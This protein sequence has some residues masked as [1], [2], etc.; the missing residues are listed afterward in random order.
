M[1]EADGLIAGN[2]EEVWKMAPGGA[3]IEEN[4]S[5]VKGKLEEDYAALWWDGK[6]QRVRG[7]WCDALI[8]D[9]GCSGFEVTVQGTDV[10]LTGEWEYQGKRRPWREVFRTTTTALIQTLFIGESGHEWKL[11]ETIRGT[12]I[13]QGSAPERGFR[14]DRRRP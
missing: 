6:A 10:V 5:N 14:K 8:N 1:T 2:G 9:E 13:D 11:S 12:R 7:I 3:L 4:R